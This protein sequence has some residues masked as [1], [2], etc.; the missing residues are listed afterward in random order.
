M[1]RTVVNLN[2]DLLREAMRESGLRRKVDLVNEGLRALAAQRKVQRLF[3]KLAGRVAWEGD[4]V[5]MRHGR[6]RSR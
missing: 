1:A 5:A 4:P 2:E 3:R 6:P